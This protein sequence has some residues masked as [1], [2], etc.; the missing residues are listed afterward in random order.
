MKIPSKELVEDL[1]ARTL[2]NLR[3]AE[4]LNKHSFEDLNWRTDAASWSVLECVEHL[5]LYGN[6]YLPEITRRIK[7]SNYPAEEIFKSGLLGNY[8]AQSMLPREN[9]KK[10]KTLKSQD[11]QGKV[12]DKSVI[13]K[14]KAQQQE[15]LDLLEISNQVSLTRTKTSL[16]ITNY[17]KLRLGDVFRVNIYH[18]QRHLLQARGV[19]KALDSSREPLPVHKNP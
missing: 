12:L 15:W 14:F 9:M 11:P 5:N 7:S 16:S 13:D 1:K 19:L 17:I 8:F 6:F 2:H 18:N 4:D 10:I 3:L